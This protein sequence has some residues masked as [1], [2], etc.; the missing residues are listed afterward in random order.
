[1]TDVADIPDFESGEFNITSTSGSPKTFSTITTGS[2]TA[3][4][5]TTSSPLSGSSAIATSPNSSPTSIT[6]G[7]S[8][9]GAGGF[10]SGPIGSHILSQLTAAQSTITTMQTIVVPSPSSSSASHNQRDLSAG[11]GIGVGVA[12]AVMSVVAAGAVFLRKYTRNQSRKTSE[13]LPL[14][15]EAQPDSVVTLNE[16][17]A[18]APKQELSTD[19][20]ILELPA[21][22]ICRGA[23]V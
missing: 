19:E 3:G 9:P 13:T 18:E 12:V 20:Q 5:P 1:M 21:E 6:Q 17:T 4:S 16:V 11:A 10:P 15:R 2:S 23:A 22:N 8:W 7:D 14:Q